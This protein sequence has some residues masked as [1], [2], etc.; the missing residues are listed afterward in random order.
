[1]RW[2]KLGRIFVPE[3]TSDWMASH[4][5]VP[6]AERLGDDRFFR[7]YFA[8]RDKLGRSHTAF[9]II[10]ITDPLRPVDVC[11]GPVLSPGR[12][13]TFDDSGAIP[14]WIV[15]HGD[16]QL[17]YYVGWNRSVTVPFRNAVGLAIQKGGGEAPFEKL[18]G[19]I[20]DRSPHDP[21]FTASSCVLVDGARWRMWYL[22]CLRWEKTADGLNPVYH[23]KMAESDD[24]IT[25]RRHGK[26]AIDFMYPDEY[27]LSRPCVVKDADRYRM[28]YSY[29]GQTYRIGY[30]E[31]ADGF[32][33]ER[34]DQRCGIDVSQ[35]GWDSQMI[36]YPFVFDHRGTRYL[37][38]DGNDYGRTGFGIAALD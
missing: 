12:A 18:D 7:I 23:I 27:A 30:A 29:R 10:D 19:P 26:V 2:K 33:W 38:Y 13:G 6:F 4:A 20:L 31:S 35:E 34:M 36:E 16:R 11:K 3:G 32:E 14:S 25:W 24:G 28:W 9:L 22:S 5:F 15:R 1:M 37:L 8:T 17:L 21:C